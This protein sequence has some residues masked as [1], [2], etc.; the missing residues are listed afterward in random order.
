MTNVFTLANGATL[1]LR[2]VTLEDDPFLLSVYA[3][4]RADELAQVEWEPGQQEAFVKW[5]FEMQRREYDARFPDAEYDVI[6][7]DGQPAGRLWL[8]RKDDEIRLLDIA[9]LPEFQNRSAGTALLTDL[10][11]EARSTGKRL[12]HMVFVLNNDADRFYERLGFVVLEDLG[13]YKHME[14]KQTEES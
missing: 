9:L 2:P 6:E 10:I 14:W 8:G 3:S 11:D 13:G 5:Q 12:R 1:K 7:I 4:T